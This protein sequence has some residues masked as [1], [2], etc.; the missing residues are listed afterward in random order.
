MFFICCLV[1]SFFILF[2]N[3][4]YLSWIIISGTMI[5]LICLYL[6]YFFHPIIVCLHVP[7]KPIILLIN[8]VIFLPVIDSLEELHSIVSIRALTYFE[9]G[10]T[11][12]TSHHFYQ[13]WSSKNPKDKL[14]PNS[15]NSAFLYLS[16]HAH[17]RHFLYL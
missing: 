14:V 6:F 3:E 16:F 8:F 7:I 10:S 4:K 13:N 5:G 15:K 17:Y 12:C 2:L 9:L 1:C 11:H